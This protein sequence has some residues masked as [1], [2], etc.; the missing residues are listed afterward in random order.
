MSLDKLV[1]DR[2][3][4]GLRGE[5]GGVVP[6][7]SALQA[8]AADLVRAFGAADAP[9]R[10][11]GLVA[12]APGR[13][14]FTSSFGL[15]DQVLTHLIASVKL[16]V[17][18]VTLDTG[19]LFPEVYAL[20]EETE[21]R[22]GVVI[23]PFYPRHEAIEL[24][25]RQNGING[26]YHARDARKSCCDIRK[27]EPLGRALAGADLWITG[28]RAD[29]SAARGGVQLAEA[30]AER[31][32]IKFN[33]LLDWSREQALAFARSEAVPLNPLHEKGF[34]SIGCQPCTR[35]IAPG[36]PERAGRWWWEDDAA[37]ECGLHVGA[38]GKLTRAKAPEA[39][40]AR[41]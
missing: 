24:Y 14:V 5:P 26:F 20:W 12:S 39:A 33:P 29:Q 10:L 18:I 6:H 23:R 38:D 8:R 37:K 40:E 34:V 9:G 16:P 22:Y 2:R 35:A 1:S 11:A 41:S 3:L 28:L 31:G 30:D 13:I 15:E 17:E 21:R 32:L 27:V 7:E 25:V 4:T 36:E 19:R